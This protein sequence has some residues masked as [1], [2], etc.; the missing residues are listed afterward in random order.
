ML[1]NISPGGSERRRHLRAAAA[2]TVEVL[3]PMEVRGLVASSIS[4]G[5]LSM[6]IE[7]PPDVGT[8]MKLSIRSS[9]R[10]APIL[11]TAQVVW[12]HQSPA[13]A[14]GVA[15]TEIDERDR[16]MLEATVIQQL[17]MTLGGY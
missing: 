3:S 7:Q 10:V 13:G 15:F 11:A 1:S 14:L 6:P 17:S 2:L 16:D 12:R 8:V 4:G 9:R 5:G